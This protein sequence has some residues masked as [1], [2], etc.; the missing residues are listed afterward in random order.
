MW[1]LR[2]TVACRTES[3][4]VLFLCAAVFALVNVVRGM[5]FF[6][7]IGLMSDC[8]QL[9]YGAHAMRTVAKDHNSLATMIC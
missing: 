7:R 3:R 2:S 9:C 4:L 5:P 1:W 8:I 6:P